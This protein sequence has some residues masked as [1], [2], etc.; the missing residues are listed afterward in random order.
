MHKLLLKSLIVALLL[1]AVGSAFA[2]SGPNNQGDRL[3]RELERTD[4]T[5]E[6]V[7]EYVRQANVPLAELALE[8]AVEF[9]QSA[10]DA[11]RD[12]R[13]LVA[14]TLTRQARER[15]KVALN[16]SRQNEQYEGAVVRR[17]ERAEE[18]LNRLRELYGPTADE[19]ARRLYDSIRDNLERAWEFYR[20]RQYKPALKLADQVEQA[21]RKL[22]LAARLGGADEANFELRREHVREFIAN[23]EELVAGCNSGPATRFMEQSRQLLTM[24]EDLQAEGRP[25][26]ALETLK[27][28]REMAMRAAR[29][30]RGEDQLRAR[31]E[32]LVDEV[33]RLADE[34]GADDLTLRLLRQ[35][36][37]QLRLAREH[38]ESGNEE[39]A[40][41][42]LQAAGLTLQQAKQ[43]MGRTN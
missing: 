42:A 20:A 18:L 34:T 31:Y 13:F 16:L 38:F 8:R 3:L 7:A 2:Q 21:A 12:E 10:R 25:G 39:A 22:M 1:T 28:S 17:L 33:E 5:L 41:A 23:A 36:R 40:A 26:Q 27:R 15:A 14:W 11:F 43:Q 32:R 30:C 35:T 19:N 37:E 4:Q 29:E 6:R 9:Q 24:A